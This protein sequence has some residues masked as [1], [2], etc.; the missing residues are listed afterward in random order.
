MSLMRLDSVPQLELAF[1]RA[2][3]AVFAYTTEAS[4]PKCDVFLVLQRS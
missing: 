2:M 3:R 4:S 1:L